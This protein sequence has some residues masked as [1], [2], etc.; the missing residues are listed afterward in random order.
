[1]LFI[2]ALEYVSLTSLCNVGPFD[3]GL[4]LAKSYVKG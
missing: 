2:E 1:M 4:F 3:G